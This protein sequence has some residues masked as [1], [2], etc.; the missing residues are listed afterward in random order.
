MCVE[1]NGP[2]GD[3]SPSDN[4]TLVEVLSSYASSGYDTDFSVSDAAEVVCHTCGSSND[5]ALVSTESQRRLEGASDPDD[6]L[7]VLALVC[8]V[9]GARG[10]LVLTYGPEAREPEVI[11]SR[12]IRDR[13]G[14][15]DLPAAQ[16]PGEAEA[17]GSGGEA[18][19]TTS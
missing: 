13:R 6:M 8:P 7:S 17:S 1:M 10:T 12:S 4:T 18:T 11:V 16:T 5:P 2:T 15:G 14:S 3:T 19:D 9:C